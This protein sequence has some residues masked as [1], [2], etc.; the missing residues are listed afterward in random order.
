[1]PY[2]LCPMLY[3]LCLFLNPQSA[4]RNLS[5]PCALRPAPWTLLLSQL[6]N[7]QSEIICPL[8]SVLCPLLSSPRPRFTV[9]PCRPAALC[10]LPYALCLLLTAN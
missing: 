2:A 8:S 4:I 5:V 9:S 3:A 7:S 1:M 10:S 6:L